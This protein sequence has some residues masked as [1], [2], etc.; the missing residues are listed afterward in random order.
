MKKNELTDE[1]DFSYLTKTFKIMRITLFLMLALILQTFAN[2]AYS[3]KTKLSLDYTNTRLEVV[4][5]EIEDLT[6]F[7]FLANEKLVDLNRSISLSAKNKKIDEILDE[8]FAGTD[9]VYT[10]TDRKIILAP[11]FLSEGQQQQRTVSG[12]VTDETGQPLPGA[13]VV[14]KGTTQ[15]TVTNADGNYTLTNIPEDATL[16]FSF[17]GMRTQEVQIEGRTTF[18]VVMEEETIGI[19]EVVAIGYGVQKRR[20][21]TSSISSVDVADAVK[22]TSSTSIAQNL[23]GRAAGLTTNLMSAQPGGYVDL[24]IRGEATGRSPLIV[25]DGMPTSDFSPST[26]GRFGS[27]R[28]DGVLSSLNPNDIESIDILK[29]A[30]ATSI[31]GSKAAGGVIL[32]TTKTGKAG[33]KDYFT[34]NATASAGVQKYFNLP[35]MLSPVEYMQETNRVLY[36]NFLY[37]SRQSVYANVPKPAN[38]KQPSPYLPYYSDAEINK[39]MSGEKS[40]TDWLDVITRTGLVQDYN[41]SVNGNQNNANYLISFSAFDQKGII[42]NNDLAKYTGRVNFEQKFGEK[43]SA[44]VKVNFSQI[45]LA[46]V[47]V[48]EEGRKF[49]NAGIILAALQFDPTLPVY[50]ENGNF[51][52]N[53]RSSIFHNPASILEMDNETRME[54][55]MSTVHLNYK[56]LPELS[57]RLQTG[58]DR[59]QSENYAYNPTSTISGKSTEGKAD[60]SSNEKTNHQI[61]FLINYIKTFSENHN[62]SG[63]LGSE[64][65]K[66]AS[67]MLGVS[68]ANFPYDGAL[69]WNL[70]LGADRPSV[71]SYGSTSELLSYFLRLSYDYDFK[72]FLTANFRV[73]GSSKFAPDN[74]YAF[75][76]GI[77]IGWDLAQESFMIS[78]IINQMK[79]RAGF[80]ITGNDDIGTAFTDWYAPGANTMWGSNI[81]S[82]V[83]LA[84]L[85]NPNLTWEKQKD[86]NFGLDFGFFKNR[87]FGSVDFF[88]REISRVLGN[89]DL[90]SFNPVTSIN[91][92]LDA[93]K[94]TYGTELTLNS[95]NIQSP[96]FSWNSTITFTYYR[97]RWFKRDPSYTLG[98]NEKEKQFFGELWRYKSDGLVPLDTSDPLNIIPG[99]V[100]IL[101]LDGYLRDSIGDRILDENG[102]AQ[103]SGQPDGIIDAADLALIGVNQPF[104]IGFSNVLNFKRFDLT[105]FTYGMFNRWKTNNTKTFL[106]GGTAQSIVRTSVNLQRDVLER[107]NSDYKE[108]NAPSSSQSFT[109][110]GT[111]DFFLENAWFVRVR[112]ITLGYTLPE[113]NLQKANL[114]QLRIFCDI[115]NPFLFTPYSGTDP[116]TDGFGANE[117][118]AYPNQRTYMF[119]IEL[120]F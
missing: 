16:V 97:D 85:G 100:K 46:N 5:D 89:K 118:G 99:T 109:A 66:Y 21:V 90:V 106:G 2:E 62:F 108:G 41:L 4:L 74:Q 44:G 117:P 68:A 20:S 55:F 59:N 105:V 39:F 77:S 23:S 51:H 76:P 119:G 64:Y 54:R 91:Y 47:A 7:F 70:N 111:G 33:K 45:N 81:I 60:R 72:Y 42:R 120:N 71:S 110:Y 30:S 6:E 75:F 48:Q 103:Y 94:Q 26:V 116:E 38:W 61:Q 88:N 8:L 50:D 40:G 93:K 78:S 114:K 107:W 43:I 63:S 36:E 65:M 15:G 35:E 13:T 19:D 84:G 115:T 56:I 73:D 18:T 69:W 11:S 1:W 3:Q 52:P 112:N 92:N 86:L 34:V 17:V 67:E 37:D 113:F 96:D 83:R 53:V 28:I 14:I 27:G 98:I 32:I 101:D 10:I 29:D 82:G 104:T 102:K 12:T 57:V 24:Q 95:R 87:I 22:T 49:E 9:V 80:G 79:L 31:Y 25:I 58:F